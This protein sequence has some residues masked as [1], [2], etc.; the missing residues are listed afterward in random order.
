M[1]ASKTHT[2][3]IVI[4]LLLIVVGSLLQAVLPSSETLEK[5]LLSYLENKWLLWKLR[6]SIV[7]LLVLLPYRAY[8]KHT[9]KKTSTDIIKSYLN[10]EHKISLE[11]YKTNVVTLNR[12]LAVKR[13][14]GSGTAIVKNKDLKLSH[15]HKFVDDCLNYIASTK[16]NYSLDKTS[17]KLLFIDYK[18]TDIS[19]IT[20]IITNKYTAKGLTLNNNLLS[21]AIADIEHAYDVALL[22]IDAM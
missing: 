8:L 20:I 21:S 6:V 4:P 3:E 16:E 5:L 12:E 10:T 1:T 18:N 22:K 2:K 14:S 9:E 11:T 15:I 13:Q 7:A 19:D 17:V